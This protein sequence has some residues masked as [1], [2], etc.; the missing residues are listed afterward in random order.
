MV[1]EVDRLVNATVIVNKLTQHGQDFM[2]QNFHIVGVETTGMCVLVYADGKEQV[3]ERGR[4]RER[5]A[6]VA[7]GLYKYELTFSV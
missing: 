1:D 5:F 6:L 4:E 2:L 7:F 3:V